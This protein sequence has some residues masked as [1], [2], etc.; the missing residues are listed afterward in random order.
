MPLS[1]IKVVDL[2]RA[3]AGPTCV[4]VL[5]E[6]GAQIIK[7]EAPDPEV[8]NSE[9]RHHYDF[10]NIHPNK[11]SLTLNLKTDEGR[12]ILIEMVKRADVL[13]ENYRPDVK[14]RLGIDYDTLAEVNPRLIYCSVSGFGQ[15]GPYSPRPGLDQI[16]QGLSGI[17]SING[18]P[19][20][21]PVRVGLPVCDMLAGFFG[22]HGVMAAIIERE[23]SGKGQWVHTSLLQAGIRLMEFQA[24]RYLIAGEVPKQQGNYH[25]IGQPTGLYNAR[26]GSLII[27]AG[28][29]RIWRR[30]AEAM[31]APE[32]VDDPRFVDKAVRLKNRDALTAEIERRLAKR[33][34]AEWFDILAEIGVPAG[35]VYTVPQTFEDEQVKTLPATA[36]VEHPAL[37]PLTL[38]ASPVVLERTPAS[39]RSAAPEHGEHTD[40]ILRELGCSEERIAELRSRGAV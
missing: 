19:E 12:E 30:F 25:P 32:L 18:Q 8:N 21:G 1:H 7:V 24:V 34:V 38:L 10:Q 36:T 27:Q 26:D 3:R 23:K 15:T 37:G 9:D 2:C 13:V 22:A 28:T 39:I 31:E 11:R 33:D 40:A 4:R 16:A 5:G 17:M 35:P 29:Q 6:M 20:C 14:H